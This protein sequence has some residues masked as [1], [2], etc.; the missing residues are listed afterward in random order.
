MSEYY[1]DSQIEYLKRTRD[2]YYNDDYLEFLVKSVWRITESVNIIDFGCG[3]GYLG[4]KLLPYYQKVQ[5]ILELIKANS[6]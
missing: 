6:L 5:D 4:L 2:L 1:W 3:F